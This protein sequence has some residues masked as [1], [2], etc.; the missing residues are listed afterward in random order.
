MRNDESIEDMST[1]LQAITSELQ[2]LKKKFSMKEL[3][4][5][6]LRS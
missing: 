5:K 4:S 1:R 2:D 6:I 3:V